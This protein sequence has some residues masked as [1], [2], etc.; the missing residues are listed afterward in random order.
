[1]ISLDWPQ[2]S[3]VVRWTH[4]GQSVERAYDRPPQ[5]VMV[6]GDRVLVVEALDCTP[7]AVT[8]NAVVFAADG[9]EVVR[10]KAPRGLV[11]EPSWVLGFY[12]AY[13]DA[14]GQPIV[15]V[16]TQVGDFWGRPDVVEGTLV[17][18]QQWR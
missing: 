2:G 10:L 5:S 9:A 14:D 11:A 6:W 13:P 15:V 3:P 18:V 16:S 1:M 7:N 8:D 17:D 4:D 12:Q